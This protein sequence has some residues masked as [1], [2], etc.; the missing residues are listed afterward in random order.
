MDLRRLWYTLLRKSWL[1]LLLAFIGGSLAGWYVK[2]SY[3]PMYEASSTLFVMNSD[4]TEMTGQSL[5]TSDINFSRELVTTYSSI[6]GSRLI[7]SEAINRLDVPGLTEDVLGAVVSAGN[8]KDSSMMSISAVWPDPQTAAL[9]CNT[10]SEVFAEKVNE[11][12]NSNSV[13][14]IDKALVPQYPLPS[15]SRPK[16][17][18]GILMGLMLGFGIVYCLVQFDNTVHEASDI[19][20]G[21]G[22][23]VIGIIP[24]HSIK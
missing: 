4:K 9:I 1:V 22:V 24:E 6:I 15:N 5:D 16:I 7:T 19:E 12:T 10:V 17:A 3:V 8:Q 18:V 20:D 11:L 21:L 14:I 23:R 2:S 13:G